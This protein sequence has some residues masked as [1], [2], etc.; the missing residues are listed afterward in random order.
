MWEVKYYAEVLR[1]NDAEVL[2]RYIDD[3]Y[4][5]MPAL[6]CKEYGLGKAYYQAARC[7]LSQMDGFFEK[8]L[9]EAKIETKKLPS[10]I[11][12]HKRYGTDG[13]YEFYLNISQ[14]AIELENLCGM[15]MLSGDRI[16]GSV[17]LEPKGYVVVKAE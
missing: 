13:V 11:E 5:D 7:S 2:G 9:K 8:L 10:G 15:N 1:V 16:D 17:V 3:F 4:K 14:K 12:F 6:T